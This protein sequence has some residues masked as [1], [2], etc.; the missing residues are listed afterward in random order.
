MGCASSGNKEIENQPQLQYELQRRPPSEIPK[1]ST[2]KEGK[3]ISIPTGLLRR[4]DPTLRPNK[5]SKVDEKEGEYDLED[6]NQ[7]EEVDGLHQSKE[8]EA[9]EV[10][11]QVEQ[12]GTVP[13]PLC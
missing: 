1:C 12:G 5:S 8:I 2:S 4:I 10:S 9:T 13:F 7:L 3:I 6:H 11:M